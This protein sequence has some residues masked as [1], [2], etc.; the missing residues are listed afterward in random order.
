MTEYF[1]DVVVSQ[2][3]N[4]GIFRQKFRESHGFTKQITEELIWRNIFS[5]RPIF[6]FFH[7]VSVEMRTKTRSRFLQKN[8]H[9]SVKSTFF[10]KKLLK[11]EFHRKFLSLMEINQTISRK[12]SIAIK[13]KWRRRMKL[14]KLGKI[15]VTISRKNCTVKNNE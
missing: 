8:Q 12:N 4:Y 11:S 6:S 7:T 10:I 14:P 1:L 13:K 9:F 15:R 5:V 2:C 3:G